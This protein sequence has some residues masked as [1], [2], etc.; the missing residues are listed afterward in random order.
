M[1]MTACIHRGAAQVGGTCIE[2]RARGQR[3][4]LDLGMPLDAEEGD[5]PLPAVAGLDGDDPSLLGVLLSHLHGDHCGLV[6]FI[7][8]RVPLGMGPVAA[9]VLREAAFFT[10]RPALPPARWEL[11]D[12]QALEI[13]PFRVTPYQVEHSAVDAFALLVEA[14]GRRLFYTGDFRAH[15]NDREPMRRLLADPPRDVHAM[16]MEGTLLG[17]GRE[18]TGPSEAELGEA[19][20]RRFREWPGIVLATWSSQNLDRTRTLYEAARAAGRTLVLDLYSATLAQAAGLPGLPVPGAPGLAVYCRQR[21]RIQVKEACE[22]QRTEAVKPWRLFPEDLAS[23]GKDLVLMTR[24]S[25]LRELERAGVLPGALAV[26]SVWAG[27]LAGPSEARL[28]A[29]YQ[30]QGVPLEVHHVSGHAYEQDLRRL[31]DAVCP[32]QL[33]PVHTERPDA[34]G[35]IWP[36]VRQVADGSR[37]PV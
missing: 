35:E 18:P 2:L 16:F 10:G 30:R 34:F 11:R 21:E 28:R 6:P 37:W 4:L 24:P 33:V 3:L 25:M 19:L 8:D 15:G 17:D 23:L 9:R 20:A 22:F 32:V 12:R 29:A 5:A 26:W 31:V 36:R 1:T 13:G 14:E 7:S 27:Y